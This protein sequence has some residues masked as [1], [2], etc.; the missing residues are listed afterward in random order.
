MLVELPEWTEHDNQQAPQSALGMRSPA[1]FYAEWMVKDE[2]Q[3][4]QI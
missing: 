4:V 3:P 2:K 1:E